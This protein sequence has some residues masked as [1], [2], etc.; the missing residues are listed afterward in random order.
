MAVL[1]QSPSAV[2]TAVNHEQVVFSESGSW[3][4]NASVFAGAKQIPFMDF[5]AEFT[6]FLVQDEFLVYSE[7]A[8][9]SP[10]NYRT[11]SSAPIFLS[12]NSMLGVK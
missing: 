1:T 12:V 3:F 10:P 9:I 8:H 6:V 2:F 4:L 5:Q 7:D 11:S